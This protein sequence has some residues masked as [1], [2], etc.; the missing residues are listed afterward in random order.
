MVPVGSQVVALGSRPA[1]LNLPKSSARIG[2][3]SSASIGGLQGFFRRSCLEVVMSLTRSDFEAVFDS[4]CVPQS[5]LLLLEFQE[6]LD[7]YANYSHAIV[8]IDDHDKS[9]LIHGGSSDPAYLQR[10]IPFAEATNSGSFYA[11]WDNTGSEDLT[12]W[13]VV[14][15]G[16]EGG[17]WV[18]AKNVDELLRITTFDQEPYVDYDS[19]VYFFPPDPGDQSLLHRPSKHIAKYK[20]WLKSTLGIESTTEPNEIVIAAQQEF[21]RAFEDWVKPF[22]AHWY[23]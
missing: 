7:G 8:L 21:E 16:D 19:G 11:L 22:L 20:S 5:L 3:V 15:F 1:P 18:V 10:L 17:Q 2:G 13:P 23:G 12:E 4:K 6:G 14:I 9:G